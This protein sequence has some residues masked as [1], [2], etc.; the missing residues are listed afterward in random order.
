MILSTENINV[1]Q[2]LNDYY[3]WL[4]NKTAW[5]SGKDVIEITTP[6]LDHHNDH[7]QIY[8]KKTD[9]GFILSD[10]GNT[11]E[12][13]KMCGC[14]I[15]SPK[16]RQ[17][18]ETTL[19]GFAVQFNEG[20]LFVKASEVN[21]AVQKHSLLQA[22]L[23]VNDMFY[24]SESQVASIF[25]EDVRNWLTMKD[26]RYTPDIIIKG[27]SG[28]DR[29][30]DFVIPQSKRAPERFIKTVNNPNKSSADSIVMDWWDTKSTR[31]E[32]TKLFVLTNDQDREIPPNFENALSQYEL[33]MVPWTKRDTM[34]EQL[35][36]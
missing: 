26:I 35:A 23:A 33:I 5:K 11:I 19:R 32:S 34:Q 17:L 25:Y 30:F 15:T 10:F 28:F 18:L 7:I 22:I 3:K 36:A 12:D 21:F 8:L 31:D 4:R 14:S 16:R 2:L 6:Y 24:L 20:E 13:L 1:D 9:D 29:K 27:A